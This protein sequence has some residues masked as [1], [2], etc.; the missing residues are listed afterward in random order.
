MKNKLKQKKGVSKIIT[1]AMVLLL[2]GFLSIVL[3]KFGSNSYVTLPIFGEKYLSGE[4]VKKM[5]K[6]YP[7]TVYHTVSPISFVDMDDRELTMF[8]NDTAIYIVNL[9]FSDDSAF[10]HHNMEQ[11]KGISDRFAY[12]NMVQIFSIS[13]DPADSATK[14]RDFMQAYQPI[15]NPHWH[16]VSMPSKDIFEYTRKELLLDAMVNP[17][18]STTFLIDS[19]YLLIDS[20]HRIRGMY[21]GEQ[22]TEI[23]RLVDEVKLLL[24][25]E[26]RN[27]PKKID[28]KENAEVN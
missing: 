23:K 18:D 9:F 2:P 21:E 7:D 11:L 27:R 19:R 28:K 20:K 17:M 22:H 1:L 5:G 3:N 26:V 6:E 12:N 24:V 15:A 4:V 16:I 25:E 14:I 8:N 13:V 10:S